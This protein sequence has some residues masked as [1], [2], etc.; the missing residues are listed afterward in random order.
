MVMLA[1][2]WFVG[3]QRITLAAL[4]ANVLVRALEAEWQDYKERKQD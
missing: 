1:I 4:G 3:G 2:I